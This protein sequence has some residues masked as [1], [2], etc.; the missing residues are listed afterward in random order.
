MDVFVFGNVSFE[1]VMEFK[2][3]DIVSD[4]LEIVDNDGY[5]GVMIVKWL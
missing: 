4:I 5:V 2:W 1:F 3:V